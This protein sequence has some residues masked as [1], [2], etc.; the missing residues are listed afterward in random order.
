MRQVEEQLRS[1]L[2]LSDA[3][4]VEFADRV[5]VHYESGVTFRSDPQ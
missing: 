3:V 4:A 5:A 2:N 1:E